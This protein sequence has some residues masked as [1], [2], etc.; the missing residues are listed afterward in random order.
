MQARPVYEG[1][2][3]SLAR[4]KVL[5]T[6]KVGW[7]CQGLKLY[8]RDMATSKFWGKQIKDCLD[9]QDRHTR[10]MAKWM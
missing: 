10:K 8:L 2:Y 3:W 7:S 9:S 6:V 4:H 5:P 1:K